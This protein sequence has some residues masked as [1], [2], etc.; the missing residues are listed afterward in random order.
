[1]STEDLAIIEAGFVAPNRAAA[2]LAA[3]NET[4]ADWEGVCGELANEIIG[5][6]DDIIHV[7]GEIAW[8]YHMAALIGGLIHDAWCEG[9]ALPL[10]DWL[11]KMFGAAEVTVALNGDDIY[12][13]P[14][15]EFSL[16]PQP[17]ALDPDWLADKRQECADDETHA[18][19]IRREGEE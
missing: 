18:E 19:M 8:R 2:F 9:G 1:M 5:P 12:T 16:P 7:E 10:A 4:V 3:R 15:D 17:L 6:D 11:S 14:A 13:G